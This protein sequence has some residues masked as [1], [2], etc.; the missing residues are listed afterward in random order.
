MPLPFDA[1]ALEDSVVL[2]INSVTLW[3]VP[4][5][6]P[7]LAHRWM[8]SIALRMAEV[9]A[10][11]S[12]SS[13]AGFPPNWRHCWSARP[14]KVGCVSASR[15]SPRSSGAGAQRQ[16]GPQGPRSPPAHQAPLPPGGDPRSR[17]PRRPRGRRHGGDGTRRVSLPTQ[18][19]AV[20]RPRRSGHGTRRRT[21]GWESWP[22][23]SYSPVERASVR[24]RSGCC[25]AWPRPRSRRT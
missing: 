13:P 4:E 9:Q 24:S 19:V 10:R 6:R 18:V 17:W 8:V 20:S 11:L 3:R 15:S 12:T 1:R 14:S 5:Q 22:L 7:R 2:S 23:H 16:P 25:S 21:V